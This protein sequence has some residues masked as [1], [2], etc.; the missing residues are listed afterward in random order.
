MVK[1]HFLKN[2]LFWFKC[3]NAGTVCQ[4]L[5]KQQQCK[6]RKQIARKRNGV[7]EER[8]LYHSAQ[9]ITTSLPHARLR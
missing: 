3:P 7:A 9:A 5:K 6:N 4:I 2:A 8:N 1:P